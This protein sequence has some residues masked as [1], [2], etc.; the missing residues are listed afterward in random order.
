MPKSL[1][2]LKTDAKR[3][4][5]AKWIR[6]EA[7]ERAVLNGCWFHVE[8]GK[9]WV[10]GI[11]NYFKFTRGPDIGEPYKLL[12]WHR[13]DFV[14]PLF[15]WKRDRARPHPRRVQQRETPRS[16]RLRHTRRRTRRTRRTDPR[17]TPARPRTSPT[18][19]AR[20]PPA[21]HQPRTR[22]DTMS[23]FISNT[24]SAAKSDTPQ[25][26]LPARCRMAMTCWGVG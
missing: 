11:E 15:G 6:S 26:P 5:W 16:D 21:P 19:P 14:M 17:G 8:A 12:D 25:P 10:D 13:D 18:E 24:I 23:W 4:G 2:Q 9:S 20:L 3:E 1:A 22:A 7:D